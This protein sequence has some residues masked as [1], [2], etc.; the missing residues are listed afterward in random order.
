MFLLA[1]ADRMAQVSVSCS[2]P[3]DESAGRSDRTPGRLCRNKHENLRTSIHGRVRRR[4]SR[5]KRARKQTTHVVSGGASDTAEIEAGE[6]RVRT[7]RRPRCTA[8]R[9]SRTYSVPSCRSP[10]GAS[11]R[12][13][14]PVPNYSVLD[15]DL[16]RRR[17]R[18]TCTRGT[19]TPASPE[20]PSDVRARGRTASSG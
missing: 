18:G 19:C 17:P 12:T 5:L 6:R 20:R 16:E 7:A 3:D 9:V 11:R 1:R 4:P 15:P 14:R 13:P 8:G 10:I 2:V